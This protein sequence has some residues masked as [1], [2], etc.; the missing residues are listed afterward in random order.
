MF[1]STFYGSIP[2]ILKSFDIEEEYAALCLIFT[3]LVKFVYITIC[4]IHNYVMRSHSK[5]ELINK[6]NMY[7]SNLAL[8][9]FKTWYNIY[10]I[11]HFK[12]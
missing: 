7:G 1:C 12:A 3:T 4:A 5:S 2:T 11:K 6:I 10:K 9:I 8:K